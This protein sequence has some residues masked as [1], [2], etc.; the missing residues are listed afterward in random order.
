MGSDFLDTLN[1]AKSMIKT[2]INHPLLVMPTNPKIIHN[3]GIQLRIGRHH[4][5]ISKHLKPHQPRNRGMMCHSISDSYPSHK[6]SCNPHR[7]SHYQTRYSSK[8]FCNWDI[9]SQAI[10]L[11]TRLFAQKYKTI[12]IDINAKY[13]SGVSKSGNTTTDTIRIVNIKATSR[14]SFVS[15]L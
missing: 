12:C 11:S 9:D 2:P 14:F 10:H 7:E 15:M 4:L 8:F 6:K 1:S 5:L 13:F 3:Q